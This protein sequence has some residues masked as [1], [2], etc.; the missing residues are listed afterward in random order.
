L[1]TMRQLFDLH[2][3]DMS[4]GQCRTELESVEARLADGSALTNAR[5]VK[6][7][8]EETGKELLRQHTSHSLVVEE[9]QDK[10]NALEQRLYG[11]SIRN[12]HELESLQAESTYAKDQA[13]EAEDQVL[14]LMIG[15]D[16]NE[17]A[18]ASSKEKLDK[19][20]QTWVQ[21][22]AV[23]SQDRT[24]LG[25]RI[26]QLTIARREIVSGIAAP[27]LSQYEYVRNSHQ[28]G[29]M[30]KVERGMCTGCRLTLPT[31]ELQRVRAARELITCSSCGRIL[32]AD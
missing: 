3:L 13:K 16:E 22:Q 19:M 21:T 28:G 7:K 9:L 4:M 5:A 14:E 10:S 1:T 27:I 30:A 6:S 18:L 8:L 15:L 24:D 26:E 29:A 2:E 11:G 17:E 25:S 20:E 31:G 23:L 32:V 12:P